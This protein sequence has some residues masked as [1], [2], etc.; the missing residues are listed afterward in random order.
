MLMESI[1][2]F[3]N[4]SAGC[5]LGGDKSSQE[6]KKLPEVTIIRERTYTFDLGSV[7]SI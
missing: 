3:R 7:P 1:S 4:S 2:L 5:I 6:I